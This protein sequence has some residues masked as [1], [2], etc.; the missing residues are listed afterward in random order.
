MQLDPK[1]YEELKAKYGVPV[2]EDRIAEAV[3]E[4][5]EEILAQERRRQCRLMRKARAG[6]RRT[7]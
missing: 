2:P 4:A 1:V 7:R 5:R 3:D 6:K